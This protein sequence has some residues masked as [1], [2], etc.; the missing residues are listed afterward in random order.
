MR[1]ITADVFNFE[2]SFRDVTTAEKLR[3]P[4]FGSHLRGA[5]APRLATG[6]FGGGCG[7]GRLLQLWGSGYHSQKFFENSDAKSCILV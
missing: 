5:C 7:K 6:R 3:G 1:R 4:R 2:P